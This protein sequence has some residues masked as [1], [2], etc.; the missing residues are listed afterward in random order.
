MT[1]EAIQKRK[2]DYGLVILTV[3]SFL[4]VI[5]LWSF[6]YFTL[7]DLDDTKKSSF[8]DMFGGVNALFSGLAFAG[9][10]ITILLQRKELILQRLELEATR[11]ELKRTANAQEKSET[12]LNKQAENL[13]ISAKLTA[14]NTLV[15]Y[16]SEIE[17]RIRKGEAFEHKQTVTEKKQNYLKR[18]EEILD[19][20]ENSNI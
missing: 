13:K 11:D 8:G 19:A 20:K 9:I 3:L 14:L 12:A 10:I 7:K 2:K 4:I 5:G 16:Y 1:Q 18:I 15:T 6:S 17:L